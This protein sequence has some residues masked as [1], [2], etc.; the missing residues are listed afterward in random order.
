[1]PESDKDC[2]AR[3]AAATDDDEN[4][5]FVVDRVVDAHRGMPVD[6][7]ARFDAP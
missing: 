6:A 3:V 5:R 1:M 4:V 2:Y 7:G